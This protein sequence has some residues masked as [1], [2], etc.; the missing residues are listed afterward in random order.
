MGEIEFSGGGDACIEIQFEG[1]QATTV[2]CAEEE[3]EA[4]LEAD[5]QGRPAPGAPARI[6]GR[7]SLAAGVREALFVVYTSRGRGVC[8]DVQVRRRDRGD[9][10]PLECSRGSECL[11]VCL[12]FF[13]DS[14]RTAVAGTVSVAAD[15]IQ[16]DFGD[17]TIDRYSLTGPLL[18][19]FRGQR[20]FVADTGRRPFPRVELLRDGDVIAT[21]PPAPS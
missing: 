17:G 11:P 14:G 15:E 1:E 2:P 16:L 7:A 5:R 21:S 9:W 8:W 12:F 19:N 13:D 10:D 3:L 4:E 6:V 18:P 20:M